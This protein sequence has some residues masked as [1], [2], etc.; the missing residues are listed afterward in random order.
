MWICIFSQGTFP[1]QQEH[2][3]GVG[4]ESVQLPVLVTQNVE[5]VSNLKIVFRKRNFATTIQRHIFQ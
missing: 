4:G 5:T 2:N 3:L 1:F